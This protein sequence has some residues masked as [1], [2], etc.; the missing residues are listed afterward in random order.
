MMRILFRVLGLLKKYWRWLL[1]TYICLLLFTAATLI[2]PNFIGVVID[3]AL[4]KNTSGDM[5]LL[6]FYGLAIIGVSLARGLFSFGQSYFAE[7]A[8]Q[9]VAYDLRNSLYD[10]IQRLSFSF[11]DKAQTGQLMSG[12]HKMS[13]PYGSSCRWWLSV[14]LTLPSS[15]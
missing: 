9:K 13:N 1:L 2:V 14:W 10:Q 6:W 15:S 7:Y 4:V 5:K 12:R 8:G 11:H 3:K